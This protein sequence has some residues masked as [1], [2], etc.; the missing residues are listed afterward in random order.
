MVAEGPLGRGKSGSWLVS[1]RKSYLE[2]LLKQIDDEDDFGFGFSDLQSKLVYDVAPAHRAELTI[3]AGRSRLDQ[4]ST[5]EELNEVH[6]GRNSAVLVNGSW[7]FTLSPRVVLTQ[8]LALGVND[9]SNVNAA[10]GEQDRGSGNDVTWR[11]DVAAIRSDALTIEG[12]AQAQWQRR[13]LTGRFFPDRALA[14][15]TE[16]YDD[17]RRLASAYAQARWCPGPGSR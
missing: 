13:A 12:G 11:A 7:R 4:E 2:L 14:V 16:H 6:D 1:A 15:T 5:V 10:G 17:E 9:C 8:R 3:V